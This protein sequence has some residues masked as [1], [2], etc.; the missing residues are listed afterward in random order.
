VKLSIRRPLPLHPLGFA[1]V[2]VLVLYA[3]NV[4]Q[5][6]SVHDALG[7][8]FLVLAVT[9]GALLVLGLAFRGNGRKAALIGSALVALFFAFGPVAGALGASDAAEIATLAVEACLIAGVATLVVRARAPAVIGWTKGLNVVAAG[10]VVLN[11]ASATVST[12]GHGGSVVTTNVLT[13]RGSGTTGGRDVFLIVLDDYGGQRAMK[14]LLG[15]DNEPFLEALRD[16][17]FFVPRHPTTNYPHTADALG[18]EL[19]LDYVQ[20]LLHDPAE[21]D[22]SPANALLK[23]D[24]VPRFLKEHGYRY[25][26]IGSWWGPTATNP[27]ADVNVKMKG[28]RSEFTNAFIQQTLPGSDTGPLGRLN[29]AEQEFL[30]VKFQLDQIEDAAALP[31]K[32]FVFGHLLVPHRPFVFGADGH[33]VDADERASLP[34]SVNY[35]N[36]LRYINSRV[37]RLIDRLL[38]VPSARRPI[39]VLQS[40][41]GFYSGLDEGSDEVTPR[42]LEQHFGTLESFSFP[43]LSKTRLYDS[44]TP[45]NVFR[46]LFDDYFGTNLRP[47][48][49]RN[50]VFRDQSHLYDFIDVTDQVRA[51]S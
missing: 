45:V 36:Q 33:Y 20:R 46:L 19:N 27:Q 1:A 41:E 21:D 4:K 22:W 29:F 31:G 13:V 25:V 49:D 16:R 50:Y 8:L 2:P 47:L 43:G 26:H 18:A 38:A 28:A 32:T 30:R 42:E 44:M 23:E 48:P 3:R 34:D 15:Y 14:D 40:D 12:V 10:L 35:L 24:Q 37:L 6:A 51:V 11:L 7:P 5:G 39:I 9:A 17:G